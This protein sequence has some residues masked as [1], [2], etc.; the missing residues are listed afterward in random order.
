MIQYEKHYTRDSSET[1]NQDTD[2]RKR[3]VKVKK[4]TDGI[5]CKQNNKA[6]PC[7]KQEFQKAFDR[8]SKYFDNHYNQQYTQG[9]H[10]DVNKYVQKISSF[11]YVDQI[12]Q[13]GSHPSKREV[14]SLS[15]GIPFKTGKKA[16]K[17]ITVQAEKPK[18]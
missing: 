15:T 9:Q 1:G 2:Y 18:I 5:N 17:R 11:L 7:M 6:K 4:A 14:K 12:G 10:T 13:L 3:N 8:G 16:K